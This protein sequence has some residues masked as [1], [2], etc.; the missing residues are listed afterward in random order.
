MQFDVVFVPE[1]NVLRVQ[2][3]G[4]G[5]PNLVEEMVAALRAA[6]EFLPGI[7]VLIDA[8]RTDYAPSTS[9]AK[10]LPAFF[11]AQLPGSRLAVTVRGGPQYTVACL[12]EAVATRDHVPLA[13]FQD[14]ADAMQWLTGNRGER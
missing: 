7:G 14:R 3:W 6:P 11:G 8:L 5:G 9:E 12:V 10:N 13:V 1:Y 2:V 4:A